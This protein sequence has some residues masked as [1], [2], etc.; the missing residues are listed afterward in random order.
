MV[1]G[2]ELVSDFV[3]A[4]SDFVSDLLSDFVSVEPLT[5][6]FLSELPVEAAE[7]FRA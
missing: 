3:E 1:L 7:F 6:V 5:S 4:V 2:A